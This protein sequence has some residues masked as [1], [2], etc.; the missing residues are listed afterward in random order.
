MNPFNIPKPGKW[1]EFS[2]TREE[3]LEVRKKK[4][5]LQADTVENKFRRLEKE[6]KLEA[7][8]ERRSKLREDNGFYKFYKIRY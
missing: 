3:I 1:Y 2:A 6:M 5:E 7:I 8:I 4:R